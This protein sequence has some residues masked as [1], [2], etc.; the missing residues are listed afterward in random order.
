MR[1]KI[2]GEKRYRQMPALG[3]DE[4]IDVMTQRWLE[5]WRTIERLRG[6]GRTSIVRYE[7]LCRAPEAVLANLFAQLGHA[8]TCVATAI[9]PLQPVPR[10]RAADRVDRTLRDRL[11]DEEYGRLPSSSVAG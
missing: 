10:D 4:L 3:E 11:G 2:K 7:E 8:G 9:R 1:R 5:S 6:E